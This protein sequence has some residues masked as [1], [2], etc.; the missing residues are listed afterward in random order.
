VGVGDTV[1][2]LDTFQLRITV[3][4]LYHASERVSQKRKRKKKTPD[5]HFFLKVQE[6][7]WFAHPHETFGR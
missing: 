2:T 3:V 7:L 4:I 1:D 5:G 6:H